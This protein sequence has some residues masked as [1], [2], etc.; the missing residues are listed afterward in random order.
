MTTFRRLKYERAFFPLVALG[1]IGL[2]SW[3]WLSAQEISYES[4]P[5]E[6][7]Q[8]AVLLLA[9]VIF[10][11]N[12][13]KFEGAGRAAAL[14]LCLASINMFFREIDFRTI[15]VSDLVLS[16]TT[17][18]TRNLVF[19]CTLLLICFYITS[20]FTHFRYIVAAMFHWRAWP[21]YLWIVLIVSGELAEEA[22]RAN[23]NMFGDL[24]IPHGQFWEE[25]LELNAYMALL[26]AAITFYEF[27]RHLCEQ[28]AYRAK[29]NPDNR[30]KFNRPVCVSVSAKD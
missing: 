18:R 9:F 26:F 27:N 4:G 17:G 11:F 5:I 28:A 29:R 3:W 10:L 23:G 16:I 8:A 7:L 6:N 12:A 13:K 25:M 20:H 2:L 21:Y 30:S 22:S 24:T 19:W 1:N 14:I 15:P